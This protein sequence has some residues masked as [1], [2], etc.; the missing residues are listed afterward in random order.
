MSLHYWNTFQHS[1]KRRNEFT[2]PNLKAHE[3]EFLPAALA[4]QA[5]PVSPTGR[6]VARIL[7]TLIVAALLWSILGKVD[8]IVNADGKIIFDQQTKTVA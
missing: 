3:A 7:M 8:I 2:P 5:A 4:L 1:W 6:W